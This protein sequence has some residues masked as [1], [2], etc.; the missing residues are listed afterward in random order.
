MPAPALISGAG[1]ARRET[2]AFQFST[3]GG[4]FVVEIARWPDAKIHRAGRLLGPEKAS[5]AYARDRSRLGAADRAD[6]WFI[7]EGRSAEAAAAEVAA[8]LGDP[9]EWEEVDRLEVEK[10]DF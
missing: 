9:A 7:F 1:A 4:K 10:S 3:S 8:L 5:P 2:F 6:H